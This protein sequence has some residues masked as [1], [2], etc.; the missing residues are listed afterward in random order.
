MAS[1]QNGTDEEN[2][3]S[4]WPMRDPRFWL[5]A[6]LTLL[7]LLLAF[8]LFSGW[9]VFE[10]DDFPAEAE[11]RVEIFWRVGAGFI[12]LIT[13]TTVVWRGMMTDQQTREQKRQND[14]NDDAAY[15]SLLVEGTKLLGE[16][17]DHHKRAGIAI[18]ARV[19]SD[20]SVDKDGKP[21]RLQ[22]QALD[23]LA[24]EWQ[25]HYLS[26]SESNY[27]G[28]LISILFDFGK[29]GIKSSINLTC[30]NKYEMEDD[31]GYKEI[32]YKKDLRWEIT[33]VFEVQTYYG[34]IVRL[35]DFRFKNVLSNKIALNYTR[36]VN[37]TIDCKRYPDF[38]YFMC[39]FHY[40]NMKSIDWAAVFRSKFFA[41]DFSGCNFA[42]DVPVELSEA[43]FLADEDGLD[44]IPES[45]WYD[46]DNPP[47]TESGFT[48]WS[49]F[50][51]PRKRIDGILN[52]RDPTTQD[53]QPITR[54][55]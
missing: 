37:G 52:R 12:A 19:V 24:S 14:A 27:T 39:E 31:D 32:I 21:N 43:K 47:T 49:K 5:S 29:I 54:P 35:N 7:C 16:E 53:W 15:A 10:G 33:G 11:K 42:V 46:V 40:C 17:H 3:R 48:D 26:Y 20:T 50:L 1:N 25:R 2:D 13:F 45:C 51:E 41:C 34:G 9:Y 44:E 8:L 36:V 22:Q 30:T 23:I 18:L 4:G 55:F 38:K 28:F 6:S